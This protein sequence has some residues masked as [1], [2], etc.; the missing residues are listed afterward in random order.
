M[1]FSLWPF[2]RKEEGSLSELDVALIRED[3]SLLLGLREELSDFFKREYS[4]RDMFLEYSKNYNVNL[5]IS[6][7]KELTSLALDLS[8]FLFRMPNPPFNIIRAFSKNNLIVRDMEQINWLI[9]TIKEREEE[10][11]KIREKTNL[12]ENGFEQFRFGSY[13]EERKKQFVDYFLGDVGRMFIREKGGIIWNVLGECKRVFDS[14]I[15]KVVEEENEK[16]KKR[17]RELIPFPE[18]PRLGG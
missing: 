9:T 8:K 15:A 3:V 12:S 18:Y 13:Y 14:Q 11:G 10:L 4:L 7:I 2:F 1:G 6:F 5:G 16:I 17:S